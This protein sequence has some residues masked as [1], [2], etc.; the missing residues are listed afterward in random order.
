MPSDL[1]TSECSTVLL[2]SPIHE[3]CSHKDFITSRTSSY[4]PSFAVLDQKKIV[5]GI[6]QG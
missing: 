3:F 1:L 5:L 6:L 2:F 4:F